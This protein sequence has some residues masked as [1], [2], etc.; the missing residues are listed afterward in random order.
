MRPLSPDYPW[1]VSILARPFG[2][3]LRRSPRPWGL[4]LKFQSSP[5][6]SDGRY[7]TARS[8]APPTPG[9]NP[10]P[11]FRTGATM[12]QVRLLTRLDGFNPRPPFRTSAT[13]EH[14]HLPRVIYPFQSSPALSDERYRRMGVSDRASRKGFN[15]RPPF[16]TSATCGGI[17]DFMW[18]M[19]SILARPFG[20]AL[21]TDNRCPAC[22]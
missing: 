4:V 5:A 8:P 9:F 21:R 14:R 19:V 17:G 12:L 3:A 18:G 2:R 1:Q 6:L 11:P 13:P 15:P 22:G 16:R 20:R 10:R 7:A